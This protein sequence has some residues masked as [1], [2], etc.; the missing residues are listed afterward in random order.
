RFLLSESLTAKSVKDWKREC[1]LGMVRG[2]PADHEKWIEIRG[3]SGNNLRGVD[4]RI[5]LEHLVAITGVSG[6]GKS[7]LV[8]DTLYQALAKMFHGTSDKIAKFGSISGFEHIGAVELVDQSPIGRSS[9]SN[10]IT[11]VKGYDEIRALFA[12]TRE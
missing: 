11:F 1:V 7:T 12:Q 5:P 2:V 4:V 6:S 3:A 8:V 9:R 10:P